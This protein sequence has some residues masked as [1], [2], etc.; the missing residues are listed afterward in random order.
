METK[1]E[2]SLEILPDKKVQVLITTV[3]LLDG[4]ILTK[5]NFRFCLNVGELDKA[6]EHLDESYIA[7]LEALWGNNTLE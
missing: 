4:E 7:V 6:R 2:V 1:E 5:K 3:Y